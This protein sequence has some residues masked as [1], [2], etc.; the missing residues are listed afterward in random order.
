MAL[1][2]IKSKLKHALVSKP[3]VPVGPS[4]VAINYLDGPLLQTV[5]EALPDL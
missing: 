2:S 4:V 1:G 5:D 3:L